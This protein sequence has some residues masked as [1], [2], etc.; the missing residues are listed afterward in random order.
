MIITI[1]DRDGISLTG[2]GKRF[3]HNI[4]APMEDAEVAYGSATGGSTDC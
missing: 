1:N 3:R 4:P 2:N